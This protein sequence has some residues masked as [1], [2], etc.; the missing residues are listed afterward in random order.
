[1]KDLFDNALLE[2]AIKKRVTNFASSV[3]LN[4]AG[5]LVLEP[6]QDEAQMSPIFAVETG[7][8][9]GDKILDYFVGGNFYT[10]KPEMG[11]YGGF[12]GGYFKGIGKGKFKYISPN[13]SKI[14]VKGE[15]RDAI[16]LDKRLIV[17]RNNDSVLIFEK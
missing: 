8:F 4:Q 16:W 3:L 14:E 7:D 15:A 9:D 2:K 17:A 10:L 11:R 13:E 12:H 6:L 5:N 1:M